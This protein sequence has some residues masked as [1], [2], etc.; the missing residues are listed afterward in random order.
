[1][2]LVT[3]QLVS[4]P[5]R[6]SLG[7]D[8]RNL[9]TQKHLGK[10]GGWEARATPATAGDG[11][12]LRVGCFA[13]YRFSCHSMA[14]AAADRLGGQVQ[15]TH[16]HTPETERKRNEQGLLVFHSTSGVPYS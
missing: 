8:T 1:M 15:L 2:L 6:G 13:L 10:P 11:W 5:S 12:I 4:R 7:Q 9:G 16:T 14:M 3:T